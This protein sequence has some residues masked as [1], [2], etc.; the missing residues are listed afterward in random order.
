MNISLRILTLGIALSGFS[1]SYALDD[2]FCDDGFYP[3]YPEDAGSAFQPPAPAMV[4]PQNTIDALLT[5]KILDIAQ[6]GLYR[7]T[8]LTAKRDVDDLPAL[9]TTTPLISSYQLNTFFNYTP[10]MLF[11]RNG[12]SIDDLT[13]LSEFGDFI[14]GLDQSLLPADNLP[15]YLAVL[16][17]G[18]AEERRVGFLYQSFYRTANDFMIGFRLP[19]YYLERNWNLNMAAQKE[20]KEMASAAGGE[21]STSSQSAYYPLVVNDAFGFGDARFIAGYIA[22]ESDKLKTCVGL[23]ITA[24]TG[25]ALKRGL[26]GSDMSNSYTPQI[27]DLQ[28]IVSAALSNPINTT[29]LTAVGNDFGQNAIKQLG[30]IGLAAFMGMEQDPALGLFIDQHIDGWRGVRFFGRVRGA[31]YFPRTK[32]WF[33]NYIKNPADFVPA[34]YEHDESPLSVLQLNFIQ[35]QLLSNYFPLRYDTHFK[36]RYM[37]HALGGINFDIANNWEFFLGYD[38]WTLSGDRVSRLYYNDQA[39]CPLDIARALRPASMQQKLF[40]GLTYTSFRQFYDIDASLT[41]DQT[42]ASHMV[43]KDTTINIQVAWFF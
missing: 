6:L 27:L 36:T 17:N 20:L 18:F 30:A 3:V 9:F 14:R 7:T 5:F 38:Y 24:P 22:H 15:Q 19:L 37:L 34:D 32:P 35:R 43:G 10:K 8:A 4:T 25:F 28:E 13:T 16:T 29:Y 1:S 33:Y 39:D 40:G 12:D 2:F 31:A 21:A 11:S 23:D 42:I 41:F 26:I